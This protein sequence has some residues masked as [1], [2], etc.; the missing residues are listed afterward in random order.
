M[1]VQSMWGFSMKNIGAIEAFA[2]KS[3]KAQVRLAEEIIIK[4]Y[5][6]SI[7]RTVGILPARKIAIF[8]FDKKKIVTTRNFKNFER[9]LK[10]VKPDLQN[11]DL[12]VAL[13]TK[14]APPMRTV[15]RQLEEVIP[16]YKDVWHPPRFQDGNLTFFCNDSLGGK[17]ERIE[18]NSDYDLKLIEL[19]PGKRYKL[20]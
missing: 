19:G 15:I 9:F 5:S 11:Q 13:F 14:A 3:G 4:E 18:I 1:A 8:E 2:K 10:T 17:F 20:R 16:K 7:W 12:L 6:L